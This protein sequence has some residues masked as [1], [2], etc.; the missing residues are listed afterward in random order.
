MRTIT[1]FFI[2]LLF[3]GPA[4]AA[5]Y[6]ITAHTVTILST[7]WDGEGFYVDTQGTLP[8]GANCG[9]GNRFIITPAAPMQKEM[10]SLLITAIQNRSP[11][12]LHVD[13]CSGGVM[14]LKSVTLYRTP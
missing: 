11:I 10:V 14:V 9:D 1:T 5:P 12:T 13:G 3:C 4:L 7:G 6:N 2:L 8:T